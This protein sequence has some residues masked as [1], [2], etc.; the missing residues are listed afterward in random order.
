MKDKD[1]K[2]I[3]ALIHVGK[4]RGYVTYEEMN[5]LLP[6]HLI[7][8]DEM[9]N[10]MIMFS[11]LDIE[12]VNQ[13]KWRQPQD[14]QPS[15]NPQPEGSPRVADD[16]PTQRSNDPVRMYLRKMGTVPLLSRD[17]EIEIAKRIE[18]GEQIVEQHLLTSALTFKLVQQL[19]D[20]EEDR[21][22]KAIRG[23]KK[24]R[25]TRTKALISRALRAGRLSLVS[26]PVV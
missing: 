4:Q 23:G 19:V 20:D 13:A 9:D 10:V 24:P 5:T 6:T 18:E 14:N 8:A 16:L 22:Q 12:V 17:G 15:G 11:E 26:E 21:C 25:R 1:L 7:S 3:Q 2:E